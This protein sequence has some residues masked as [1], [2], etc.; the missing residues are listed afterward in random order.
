MAG[1]LRIC[2]LT[3]GYRQLKMKLFKVWQIGNVIN[4]A[5]KADTDGTAEYRTFADRTE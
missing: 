4:G 1:L 3:N 5:D 2:T